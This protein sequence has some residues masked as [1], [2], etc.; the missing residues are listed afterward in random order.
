LTRERLKTIQPQINAVISI[1]EC[2]TSGLIMDEEVQ[3]WQSEGVLVFRMRRR[4][5]Y[6]HVGRQGIA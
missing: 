3:A 1:G 6:G 5:S 2:N 4:R